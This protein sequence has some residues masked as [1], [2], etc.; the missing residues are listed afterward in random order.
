MDDSGVMVVGLIYLL[1]CLGK[2]QREEEKK[3]QQ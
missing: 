1:I 2:Q 3:Q